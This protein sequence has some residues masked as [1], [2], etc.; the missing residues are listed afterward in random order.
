MIQE[1]LIWV[2]VIAAAAFIGKKVYDNFS[3]KKG[4]A[5]CEKCEPTSAK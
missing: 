1:I 4:E 2:L 5:G 3:H